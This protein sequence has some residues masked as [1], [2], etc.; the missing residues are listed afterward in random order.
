MVE[1]YIVYM[2]MG[3]SLQI[4]L[5]WMKLVNA[6]EEV[7]FRHRA[8]IQYFVEQAGARDDVSHWEPRLHTREPAMFQ[9]RGEG[10]DSLNMY[11][12]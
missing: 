3:V 7:S 6:V 11:A 4:I 12:G 9:S 2:M 8:G 1:K 5:L 10:T